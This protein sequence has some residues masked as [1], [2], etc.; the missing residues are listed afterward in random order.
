M[1][2]DAVRLDALI[3]ALSHAYDSAFDEA[4]ADRSTTR[5]EFVMLSLLARSPDPM[6]WQQLE[7]HMTPFYSPAKLTDAWNGLVAGA[8]AED[9]E[10]LRAA[11]PEGR[12]VVDELHDEIERIHDD[13]SEG[14]TDAQ[15][16]AAE[17]VVRTMLGNLER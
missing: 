5:A 8:W 7:D 15:I 13:A 10:G 3:K 9:L 1:S 4:L 14:L 16:E 6:T 2:H 12:E 17:T 11:T